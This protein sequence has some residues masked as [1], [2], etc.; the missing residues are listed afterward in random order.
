[1]G[2]RS[3]ELGDG[4]A[5]ILPTGAAVFGGGPGIMALSERRRHVLHLWDRRYR[6]MRGRMR[7]TP[8][9]QRV[10]E[11]LR[12]LGR[13]GDLNALELGAGCGRDA[14][15][16]APLC[17]R[18]MALDG[19]REAVRL[20]R[21]LPGVMPL[22]ADLAAGL[23]LADRC[24]DLVYSHLVLNGPFLEDEIRRLAREIGRVLRPGGW[25]WGV[26]RSTDDPT[27]HA[28]GQPGAGFVSLGDD[29]LHF[30]SRRSLTRLLAPL[31][32]EIDYA[33]ERLID[34]ECY[35]VLEFRAW[36]PRDGDTAR[37]RAP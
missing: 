21:E 16:L 18:F 13:M 24:V 33:G 22:R 20:C 26:V 35:G 30:F 11:A 36:M 28:L 25:H 23:P 1:M 37:H 8:F 27:Y 14:R 5:L 10:A 9:A 2:E 32:V 7:P 19:S 6:A 15:L 34:G 17:S 29:A 3:S 31:V 4:R 12:G